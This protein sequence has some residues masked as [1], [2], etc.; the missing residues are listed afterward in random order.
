VSADVLFEFSSAIRYDP[1]YLVDG[2]IANDTMFRCPDE[3]FACPGTTI[4]GGDVTNYDDSCGCPYTAWVECALNKTVLQNQK[5]NFVSCWDEASISDKIQTETT[6]EA[7]V[8]DC[9]TEASI[10]FAEVQACHSGQMKSDLLWSA[11]NKFMKKWPNNTVMG[12]PFHV[13]HVLIG[14]IDGNDI[15]DMD[16]RLDS[17]DI[18]YFN[19]HLCSLGVKLPACDLTSEILL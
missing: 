10:D 6:L 19:G 2:Q 3:G 14:S 1:Q 9:A 15:E 18:P 4:V 16:P 13:P 5:V 7:I 12:G 11:A 8:K 17:S